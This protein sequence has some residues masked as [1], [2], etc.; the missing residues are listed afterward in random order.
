MGYPAESNHEVLAIQPRG[1][2]RRTST[3]SLVRWR[4]EVWIT[5]AVGMMQHERNETAGRLADT[6]RTRHPHP[7]RVCA[8][9]AGVRAS[10]AW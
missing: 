3:A 5:D 8:R 1:V 10:H 4:A 6:D 9:R 2:R 7:A